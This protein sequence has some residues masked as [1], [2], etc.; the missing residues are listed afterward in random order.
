MGGKIWAETEER[1]FWRVAVSQ[2]AKRVGSD[3][4]KQEKTWDL[5]AIEMQ[6]AMGHSARRQY[7]GNMLFEHFFQN[8]ESQRRS[9]HAYLY[10]QE[11]FAKRDH[12]RHLVNDHNRL[13]QTSTS[14]A[15]RRSSYIKFVTEPDATSRSQAQPPHPAPNEDASTTLSCVDSP[16]TSSPGLYGSPMIIDLTEAG[17][18]TPT[19]IG[20]CEDK[21]SELEEGEIRE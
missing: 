4:T 18:K 6:D 8:T 11:Y 13:N 21:E 9:P 7:T 3:R 19:T 10:V 2:S 15:S 12:A 5:L 1:Y 14:L 16:A 20:L 17:T